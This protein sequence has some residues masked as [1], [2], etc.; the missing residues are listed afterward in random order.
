MISFIVSK[1]F[2]QQSVRDFLAFFHLSKRNIYTLERDQMLFLNQQNCRLDSILKSNDLLEINLISL[3]KSFPLA[4]NL[5]FELIYE[6]DDLLIANKPTNMLIYSDGQQMDTLTNRIAGY[7]KKKGYRLPILPAHRIDMD[8]SG[9]VIYG[10]HPLALS[11]LSW[12][13]ESQKIIKNYTCVVSGKFVEKHG[14]IDTSM[15][16]DRHS[17]KMVISPKGKKAYTTYEV[18]ETIEETTRLNVA[19]KGGRKHQIRLHLKSIGHPIV[20]DLLYQ[21][22][23]SDRLMLHFSKVSFIHPRL[24]KE[25]SFESTPPF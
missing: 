19:I 10:K 17:S 21:G 5:S 7:A 4:S 22:L 1:N 12:L 14:V 24:L 18:I 23:P 8:T 9:I 20:G 2:D 11:Y 3:I 16:D 6:D 13:F 15:A 25:V